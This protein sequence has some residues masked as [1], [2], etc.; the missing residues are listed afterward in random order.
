M[1]SDAISNLNSSQ[2]LSLLI[3]TVIFGTGTVIAAVAIASNSLARASA[4]RTRGELTRAMLDRGLSADEIARVLGQQGH[5]LRDEPLL[6]PCACEAVVENH[7]EWSPALILQVAGGRYFVHF[8]GQEM[9][10]NEWVEESRARFPAGSGLPDLMAS[11][12]QG[13]SWRNGTLGKPPVE[14][15]V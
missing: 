15:E 9:D 12:R 1:L 5:D 4:V 3:V 14:V 8:I 6:L 7:G 13:A 10:D 11:A 2:I